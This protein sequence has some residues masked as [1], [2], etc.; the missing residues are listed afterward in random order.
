MEIPINYI[1]VDDDKLVN[2]FCSM[3]IKKLNTQAKVVTFEHPESGLEYIESEKSI[4][5]TISPTILLLDINM[6]SMTGWEFLERFELLNDRIKKAIN[7]YIL[8][9]SVDERDKER[10][11]TLKCI[12][13]YLIKPLTK[14][15]LLSTVTPYI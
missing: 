9:S 1:I 7:V 6:P 13:G 4:S 12:K 11:S 2:I 15:A 5:N 14:E 10:A 8:S 3:V